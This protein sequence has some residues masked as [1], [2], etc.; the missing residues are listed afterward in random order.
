VEGVFVF[1]YS[2]ETAFKFV[3]IVDVGQVDSFAFLQKL[4]EGQSLLLEPL[5]SFSCAKQV[6][7]DVLIDEH[8][9]FPVVSL[10]HELEVG[11]PELREPDVGEVEVFCEGAH[12]I[13]GYFFDKLL[14]ECEEEL[15]FDV[16]FCYFE[17]LQHEDEG[18]EFY[19]E[20][21]GVVEEIGDG[22]GEGGERG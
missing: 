18:S 12:G 7:D 9:E 4:P 8:H 11:E 15:I 5:S 19:L 1:D 6:I 21:G 17:E 22:L 10:P 2:S 14:N 3:S 13:I 20:A 16:G